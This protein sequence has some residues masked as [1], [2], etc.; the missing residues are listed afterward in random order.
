M[1]EVN[2]EEMQ[3]MFNQAYQGI[4]TQGGQSVDDC[5]ECMYRGE[6]GRSC[7]V[8]QIITDDEYLDRMDA[9]DHFESA[10]TGTSVT[11]L[12]I[13]GLLPERLIPHVT[14]LEDMQ[15]I[16]DN[17]DD[18]EDF[19]FRMQKLATRYDLNV[20]EPETTKDVV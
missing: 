7:A 6:N 5:G 3:T 4:I 16:H 8:G 9:Y 1:S 11:D 2:Q 13:D 15:H 18:I 12:D 14:F 19:R 10:S 20:E 17:M